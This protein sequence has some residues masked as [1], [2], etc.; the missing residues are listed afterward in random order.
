MQDS[1]IY[2]ENGNEIYGGRGARSKNCREMISDGLAYRMNGEETLVC[3]QV[4]TPAEATVSESAG[5][6][7][8]VAEEMADELGVHVQGYEVRMQ[9]GDKTFIAELGEPGVRV[10]NGLTFDDIAELAN[11]YITWMVACGLEFHEYQELVEKVHR[12]LARHQLPRQVMQGLP[13]TI[14]DAGADARDTLAVNQVPGHPSNTCFDELWIVPGMMPYDHVCQAH[15][16]GVDEVHLED[17][18]AFN[19]NEGMDHCRELWEG[20][21]REVAA[22]FVCDNLAVAANSRCLNRGVNK[23]VR[24]FLHTETELTDIMPT[25]NRPCT[26]S[27]RYRDCLNRFIAHCS[28]LKQNG[29]NPDIRLV[30]YRPNAR[31]QEVSL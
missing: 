10:V 14:H 26:P 20:D 8:E 7:R 18:P 22:D 4:E 3:M 17:P 9:V 25:M 15:Y 27:A 31:P 6:L 23:V 19:E 2:D 5:S 13:A 16:D 24:I 29:S 1:R 30:I 28:E 21:A 11:N 12:L